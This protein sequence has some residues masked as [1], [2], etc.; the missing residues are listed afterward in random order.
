MLQ[1]KSPSFLV[2]SHILNTYVVAGFE[3]DNRS[4]ELPD[5][6]HINLDGDLPVVD[7]DIS[8]STSRISFLLCLK[9]EIGEPERDIRMPY[10]V[11]KGHVC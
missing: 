1:K 7:F 4:M 5:I 6:Q 9:L 11:L 3:A 8:E 10:S 2:D